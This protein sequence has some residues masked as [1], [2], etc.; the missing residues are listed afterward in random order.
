MLS[1]RAGEDECISSP[2]QTTKAMELEVENIG[3]LQ[4]DLSAIYGKLNKRD[5]AKLM[6]PG[7][8]VFRKAVRS[9]APVRKGALRSAIRV[10]TARGKKD[11]PGAAVD[12]YFAK[13]YTSKKG[14]KGKPYYALF[15]HNGT[16]ERFRKKSKSSTGKMRPNPFVYDAFEAEVQ[17]VA[18]MVLDNIERAL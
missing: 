15:V 5:L 4:R 18:D 14:V 6:K 8:N 12:V 11:A 9:R 3:N 10:R 17:R 13:T 1:P 16:P 7:A 2:T